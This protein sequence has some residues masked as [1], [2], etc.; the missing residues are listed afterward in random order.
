MLTYTIVT[1][2]RAI[3]VLDYLLPHSSSVAGPCTQLPAA[4]RRPL[5]PG[6][7]WDLEG[8]IVARLHKLQSDF[9]S[10]WVEVTHQK[11]RYD[12]GKRHS[13]LLVAWQY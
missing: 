10:T 1:I 13:A 4:T 3:G 11:E 5:V 12:R 2:E 8:A 7:A 9:K 6:G